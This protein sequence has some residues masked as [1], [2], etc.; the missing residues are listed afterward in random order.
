MLILVVS[1]LPVSKNHDLILQHA[2]RKERLVE[3]RWY[4]YIGTD[5][6]LVVKY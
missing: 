3:V 1:N 6:I 4:R 5:F 2:T